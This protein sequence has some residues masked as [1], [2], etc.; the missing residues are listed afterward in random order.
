MNET[1]PYRRKIGFKIKRKPYK[2]VNDYMLLD[3]NFR[4]NIYRRGKK[5]ITVR[6][7]R[8]G[9]LLVHYFLPIFPFLLLTIREYAFSRKHG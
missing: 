7:E 1:T 6:G 5:R 9:Y 2:M 4:V 3:S 8:K